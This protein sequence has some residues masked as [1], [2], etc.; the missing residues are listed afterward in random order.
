MP[1]R[2][3]RGPAI[4]VSGAACLVLALAACGRSSNTPS[5][6]AASGS[7]ATSSSPSAT[8]TAAAG[9][10][11]TLKGI[12]GPGTATGATARGV[13]NT[14]IHIGVTADPGAAA[15]PGLEQEFFDTGEG[16]TKW[17]NAA[18]GINGRKIVLDKW[19]A[20]LFNVGAVMTSAC[21]KD[22]MLVGNG[23]AF[24]SAGVK[25]REGCKLGQIPAYVTSPQAVSAKYQAQSTPVPITQINDGALRLLS[26]VYPDV[27]TGGVGIGSS[28]LASITPTGLKAQEYLKDLGIKVAVLQEQPPI[29]D[30]YRPYMEQLKQ[31][32]ARAYFGISAQDP[33]PIVQAMKNIGYNPSFI[34]YSTQFY[35][36]QAVSAAKANPTFP[37][38]YVQFGALPF[39]LASKYPVLQQTESIV[40]SAVP[41]AKLTTFTL[42]AMSAWTLWAQSATECGSTLTMD[43]VLAKASNH[44]DWTAGG[45]YPSHSTK[46]GALASACIA[47]VK[48]TPT[49]FVYDE[50]ATNPTSGDAPF[51][52]DPNNVKT[53]KSYLTS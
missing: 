20:K 52:C 21:L 42:S 15:A 48:L 2:G 36:P 44:D 30:N 9:D 40:R 17:C 25:V 37:P 31:A 33:S 22:F 5:G 19:D 39:E 38:S 47:L 13:T 1:N 50:K 43:C 51:N 4:F 7:A 46:A 10:F 29:V 18:G 26:E 45:L 34:L 11:G 3:S 6:P 49:G 23:N 16:F 12:C 27:K 35:G 28:S 14:D 24:D 8:A 32:G 53:V 41:N